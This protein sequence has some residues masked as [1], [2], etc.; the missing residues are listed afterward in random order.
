MDTFRLASPEIYQKVYHNDPRG[1]EIYN[2][3]NA[4]FVYSIVP[5]LQSEGPPQ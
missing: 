3:K 1:R 2:S 4:Q 5:L